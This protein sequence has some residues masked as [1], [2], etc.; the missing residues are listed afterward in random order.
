MANTNTI[1]NKS[2]A[3]EVRNEAGGKAYNL[4]DQQA[5]AQYATTGCLNQTYYASAETQ[6]KT[7]LDLCDKV[8]PELVAK[9]AVYARERGYMKDVPALLCVW[10]ASRR[11]NDLLAKVFS[12]VIDNGKMLRN[13]VEILRSGSTGRKSMGSL[14]KRLV[15]NWFNSRTTKEIFTQSVG[16]D[17]SFRDIL[18]LAHPKPL[19]K[20]KN[21][22]YRW[23]LGKEHDAADLPEIVQQF[24][25]FKAGKNKEVPSVPFEM[26]TA[27]KLGQSE[28]CQIAMRAGW[29]WTRMNLNTMHRHDVFKVPEMVDMVAKRLTDREAIKKARVFPYQ[30]L[31]AYKNA[32]PETPHKAKEALQDALEIATENVPQ[33]PGDGY[34]LVDK[35]GSMR[36]PLTGHRKGSTSKVTCVDVAGLMASAILRKN[37]S[38]ALIPFDS[39][40]V[41]H[42][43]NPRDTVLTNA[44]KLA[45]MCNGGTNCSAPLSYLNKRAAKGE[46]VMLI[47]D[48]Q[49][50][51]DTLKNT[52][53]NPVGW[54]SASYYNAGPGYT[55][56]MREWD[57]FKERNPSASLVALD[58]Q[59]YATTQAQERTDILNIGGFSDN[60]FEIVNSFYRGELTPEHWLGVIN[61]VE[62]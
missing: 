43:L 58:I 55:G 15:A 59:P 4:S 49:S 22:L 25:A 61:A 18:R 1:E 3:E 60:V 6:L 50:W 40:V 62:L 17:P 48:N 35:S 30:L 11:H 9:T 26:L 32:G 29:H 57:A 56:F 42:S 38:S 20:Q 34:I 7:I 5:L 14:P 41:T 46:W 12:R 36:S 39:D 8:E 2:G 21:A 33:L 44:E 47:S 53:A 27:L 24:E 52:V 23:F 54:R 45:K 51:V 19:D 28:W 16:A 31:A 37:P 10:L 13:F